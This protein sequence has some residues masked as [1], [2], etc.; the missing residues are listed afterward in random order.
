[1]NA[2]TT[3]PKTVIQSLTDLK[4]FT[5]KEC[6]MIFRLLFILFL[7]SGFTVLGQTES[8]LDP[9][10]EQEEVIPADDVISDPEDVIPVDDNLSPPSQLQ[11]VP[12]QMNYQGQLV[13]ADGNPWAD[14]EYAMMFNIYD[15]AEGGQL[16]W[17]PFKL[18]GEQIGDSFQPSVTV[19]NSYFNVVL[20]PFDMPDQT[21][22]PLE[23]GLEVIAEDPE[24]RNLANAFDGSVRYLEITIDGGVLSPRQQILSAPFAFFSEKAVTAV[25][26]ESAK[27]ADSAKTLTGK[28]LA[29]NID[30]GSVNSEHIL[31]GSIQD[32]DIQSLDASK[33]SGSIPAEMLPSGNSLIAIDS[34]SSEHILDGSIKNE[35]IDTINAAKLRGSIPAG[36]LPPPPVKSSFTHK[37]E[38]TTLKIIRGNVGEDG[39]ELLQ[40]DGFTAYESKRGKYLITFHDDTFASPPSVFVTSGDKKQNKQGDSFAT[41][42]ELSKESVTVE[43]FNAG[44]SRVSAWFSFIA[45]GQ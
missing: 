3:A 17:G 2:I 12:G 33:L 39:G 1:M 4:T 25:A 14:G 23:D 42:G 7:I 44:G 43:T 28:L 22:V 37:E 34:V 5:K 18:T 8:D 13:D 30:V 10:P 9:L 11:S 40:G 29:E 27:F 35:D 16:I 38:G 32:A 20:G 41:I 6:S 15:A 26:A 36:M 31:D 21:E 24:R 19:V 45:I